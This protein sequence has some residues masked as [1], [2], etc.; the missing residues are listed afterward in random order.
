DACTQVGF[1]Y[2]A[3]HSVPKPVIDATFDAAHRFFA[4]PD[5]V[6]RSIPVDNNPGNRGYTAL[7]GENT[8]PT[9][10]GDMH[11]AFD[12][13]LDLAP[14]DPD[15]A[16][17]LFGYNPNQWPSETAVPGFREALLSYHAAALA[18]GADIFRAFALALELP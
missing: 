11:E 14:D 12:F 4:L 13:A 16:R 7:L 1:F 3:G 9:A 17:G 18:F 10:K 2:A 15:L 5:A 8:D 6:K